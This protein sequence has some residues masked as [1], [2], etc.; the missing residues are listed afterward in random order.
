MVNYPK[1]QKISLSLSK[2][3]RVRPQSDK[4][5]FF[6]PSLIHQ[7]NKPNKLIM[8]KDLFTGD[9]LKKILVGSP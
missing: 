4:N 7:L 9:Q 5:H 1:K 8:F 6:T 2:G 3:G